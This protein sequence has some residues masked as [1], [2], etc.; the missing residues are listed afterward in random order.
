VSEDIL[1]H[2]ER[3]AAMKSDLDRDKET[4]RRAAT[5]IKRLRREVAELLAAFV[6]IAIVCTDN[7]DADK[8]HRMALDFVRQIAN[9][10]IAKA[11]AV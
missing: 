3:I 6:Q 4:M 10:A 8:N 11:E 9:G 7:M 5:E 2:L 1:K